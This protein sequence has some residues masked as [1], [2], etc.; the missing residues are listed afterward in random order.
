MKKIGI[1]IFVVAAVGGIILAKMF[2]FGSLPSVEMP[3]VS[4]F[5]KVHGSGNIV[6]EKRSVSEFTQID[7]GGIFH[8]DAVQGDTFLVEVEA[9]DNLLP[10]ISTTVKRGKLRINA[11][12]RFS[13]K[14]RIKIKVTA[15]NIEKFE[16]SG[17]SSGTLESVDNGNLELDLGGAAKLTVSGK[18]GVL[19]IDMGGASKVDAGSLSATKVVVD[20]GGAS[21]ADVNVAEDLFVDLSGA[22]KVTYSGSPSNVRKETSGGSSLHQHE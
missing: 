3:K 6:T 22:S 20:G 15:P 7:V 17:A 18:T 9:D 16:L 11:E 5:S 1:L 21:K 14:N 8:V 13:S 10:L 4:L 12:K 2:S 19:T